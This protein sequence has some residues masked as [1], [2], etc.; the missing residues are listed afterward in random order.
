MNPTATPPRGI[1]L[2]HLFEWGARIRREPLPLLP[3]TWYAYAQK[4]RREDA[5]D[6]MR[7]DGGR[8]RRGELEQDWYRALYRGVEPDLDRVLQA[9]ARVYARVLADCDVVKA[10][11]R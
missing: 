5:L 6:A 3:A 7:G 11:K 10:K 9:S 2:A 4:E 8:R 1:A